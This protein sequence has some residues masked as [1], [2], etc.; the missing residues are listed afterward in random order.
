MASAS[1]AAS[2]PTTACTRSRST[3]SCILVRACA[4]TPPVSATVS[5]TLRPPMVEFF[6]LRKMVR[7]RSM[8]M[9]PD[10]SAPVLMVKRPRRIGSDCERTMA[11][12]PSCAAPAAA[13]AAWMKR[14]RSN[15]MVPSS[16]GFALFRLDHR[17]SG[18]RRQAAC[19]RQAELAA[20]DVRA[21][22][23]RH[24][25]VKGVPA[26]HAL[27]PHAA[28]GREHQPFR[29]NV[30]ERLA[31][32]RGDLLGGFHLQRVV[33]DDADADLLLAHALT[34]GLQVHAARAAGLEGN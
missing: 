13:P 3:S 23:D 14:L 34:D 5:V 25:L 28:I 29:R 4:G 9:P 17:I 15:V 7:P 33:V 30:L 32:E 22:H 11:G 21:E 16:S 26:A 1:N 10:A 19:L 12:K 6:S 2:G 8:S 27:A 24:H 18:L 31:D 20:H